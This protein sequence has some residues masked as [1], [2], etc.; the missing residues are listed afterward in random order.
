MNIAAW[1]SADG[2]EYAL[3]FDK[4]RKQRLLV[5]PA[6]FDE[7]NKTRH[8]LV[9][10]L[11][12]LDNAGIDCFLPDLP[13]CNE[14]AAPLEAQTLAG[15]R[16]AAAAAAKHFAATHL[17][18]I[19]ASAILAPPTLPGWR[20]APTGGANALRGLLRARVVS[21]REVGEDVTTEGLLETGR[22]AGLDLA[23]YRL[24]AA[25]VRDLE[26]AMLPDS[27]RLADIAQGTVGGGAPWLRAE[28]DF[29]P[30]QADALAA[31]IALGLK[32]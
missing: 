16:A 1:P 8:L 14:S 32:A 28:P 21:A 4:G 15:W 27:G 5:L 24:G 2:D 7:A 11:R 22:A 18:T 25:L 30:A 17:L 19:R 10:T 26:G 13:G 12:R 31:V 20:Y 23:G 9:E 29:D 6:L 3:A